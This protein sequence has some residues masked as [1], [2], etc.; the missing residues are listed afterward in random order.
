[1]KSKQF[2]IF[3]DNSERTIYHIS[4]SDISM[5]RNKKNNKFY[6]YVPLTHN[7]EVKDN[8]IF[9]DG[10]I[11]VSTIFFRECGCQ[12]V[13]YQGH[14]PFNHVKQAITWASKQIK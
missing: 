3:S 10:M 1:M 14:M 2:S 12:V 9:I 11:V 5:V 8:Y 4:G 6:L 7:T 13:E